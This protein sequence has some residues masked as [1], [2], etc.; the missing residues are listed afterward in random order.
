MTDV[1]LLV[2]GFAASN[3]WSLTSDGRIGERLWLSKFDTAWNG[4]EHLRNDDTGN[5]IGPEYVV[6]SSALASVYQPFQRLLQVF[7]VEYFEFAYDWRA[8]V[9]TNGQRFA[10]FLQQFRNGTRRV[11][12][13]AHSMGGLVAASGLQRIDADLVRYVPRLITL[14]T[15]WRGSYQAVNMLTGEHD[16]ARLVAGL[17]QWGT[18]TSYREWRK[19]F[20]R[21]AA[22][23]P[24]I[25][26][27]LPWPE[28]LAVDNQLPDSDPWRLT[29]WEGINSAI[30]PFELTSAP[31][32]RVTSAPLPPGVQHHNWR[33]VWKV[34]PGPMPKPLGGGEYLNPRDLY[35]D[36]TVPQYSSV[37]PD[38]WGS[39]NHNFLADHEQFAN[40]VLVHV[41]LREV[42]GF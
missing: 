9:Q 21:T 18:F 2:P 5:P 20:A 27:M 31:F 23:W 42:I 1:V 26:D 4:I 19:V 15:P 37:A 11:N 24:G 32:R 40:D 7:G 13:V 35:G 29:W 34:T 30:S 36:G 14:G 10:G 41:F 28:M 22:T 16:T 3:L 6:A 38:G 39:I 17:A 12:V 8:D 33:G 25:Y